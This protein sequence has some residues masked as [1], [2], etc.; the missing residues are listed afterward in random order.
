MTKQ[1]EINFDTLKPE[2]FEHYLPDLFANGNGKVSQ[3]PR[4]QKFLAANPDCAALVRDLETIAETARSLF[5]PV[6]DPSDK[7]WTNIQTKLREESARASNSEAEDDEVK[8][9]D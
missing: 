4:L 8:E 3:D 1:G 5:E 7:V 9:I 6:G 2:E